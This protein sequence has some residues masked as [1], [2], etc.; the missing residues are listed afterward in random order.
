MMILTNIKWM[1]RVQYTG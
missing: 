1:G